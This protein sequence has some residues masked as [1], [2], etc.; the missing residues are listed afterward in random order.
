MMF[1]S[2]TIP[3]EAMKSVQGTELKQCKAYNHSI[4]IERL[5]YMPTFNCISLIFQ[6]SS[7][8]LKIEYLLVQL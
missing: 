5:N 1:K 7:D 6:K 4:G 2:L 3:L 8:I